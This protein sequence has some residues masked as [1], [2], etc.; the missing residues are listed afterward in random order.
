MTPET[1]AVF[2][3]AAKNR[4]IEF[5]TDHAP[6]AWPNETRVRKAMHRPGDAHPVG[7]LATVIGSIGPTPWDGVY[8]YFVF[9]DEP[10]ADTV[11]CFVT[12]NALELV[13]AQSC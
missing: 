13:P 11:P 10:P 3:L 5:S 12:G 7:S 6:G 1:R 9:W 2:L 4:G 8:G